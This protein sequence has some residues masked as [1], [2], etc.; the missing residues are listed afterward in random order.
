MR[1]RAAGTNPRPYLNPHSIM[2]LR[3]VVGP[4]LR[5]TRS[6]A[7]WRASANVARR[8]KLHQEA[9]K[10]RA[11]STGMATCHS[12]VDRRHRRLRSDDVRAQGNVS[13]VSTRC[14]TALGKR[15]PP[16]QG[17]PPTTP[18]AGEISMNSP[19]QDTLDRAIEDARR[20]QGE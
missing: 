6:P 1:Q 10:I 4:S 15:T 2:E 14:R 17:C 16:G 7:E 12:H 19:D 18:E 13:C 20:I 8:R 9:S 3:R 5:S 11:P